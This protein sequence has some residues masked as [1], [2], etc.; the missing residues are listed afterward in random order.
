[1]MDFSNLPKLRKRHL[2][3]NVP[4]R[5]AKISRYVAQ[6]IMKL[7]GW[8]TVGEVPNIA[9]AVVIGVP[10]TS[11]IDGL[12]TLPA[13]LALDIDIRIMGKQQ[14]FNVPILAQVLTWCGVIPINREKKGSILQASID[15]FKQQPQL[16][17]G[18]APEGTRKY[19]EQWKTGFYYLALGA[20]VP[21]LP[22]AL[23]YKTKQLRFLPLFYPSGD[24]EQ[25]L[26][27]L[28][29]Y[30]AGVEGYYPANMSKPLQDLKGKQ[31]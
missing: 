27:K 1:M 31:Y 28:Y 17:L 30:F 11:N 13:L 14:L 22:V 25:D 24:I 3:E 4:Q 23:D 9:Q 20:N 15:K 6:S 16:F 12:Y 26:P 18:L 8:Q 10:H 19:T 2:G 29:E 21:I 5:G 7:S